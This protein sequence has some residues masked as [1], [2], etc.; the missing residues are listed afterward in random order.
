[1]LRMPILKDTRI[2]FFQ[3]T[4]LR[5]L[6]QISLLLMQAIQP[7]L[8]YSHSFACMLWSAYHLQ[9]AMTTKHNPAYLVH[10]T[11][12][13][14]LQA[15]RGP[16][17]TRLLTHAKPQ[18]PKGKEILSGRAQTA[19]LSALATNRHDLRTIISPRCTRQNIALFDALITI[20]RQKGHG[21]IE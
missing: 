15:D 2:H 1:M 11:R 16:L 3:E 4:I 7:D 10:E 14:R 13:E 17:E 9:S 18:H 5:A 6:T 19:Q 20:P 8:Q 12:K 21:R